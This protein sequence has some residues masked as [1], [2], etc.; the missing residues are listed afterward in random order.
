[1]SRVKEKKEVLSKRIDM[2]TPLGEAGTLH[3]RGI[4]TGSM[5][6]QSHISQAL[7][8]P[9]AI[10]YKRIVLDFLCGQMSYPFPGDERCGQL[11]HNPTSTLN[12]WWIK[13]IMYLNQSGELFIQTTKSFMN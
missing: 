6:N 8:S 12:L 1:M 7:C 9:C 11:L 3:L 2:A 10:H 13:K 4:N 5:T